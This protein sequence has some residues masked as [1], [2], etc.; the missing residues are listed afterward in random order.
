MRTIDAVVI[1]GVW[2]VVFALVLLERARRRRL[3]AVPELELEEP[4]PAELV[5]LERHHAELELERD[6][7]RRVWSESA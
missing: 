3:A 5:E 1:F 4:A 7:L 6:A 2:G